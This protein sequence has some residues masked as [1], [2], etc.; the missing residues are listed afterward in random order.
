I[1]NSRHHEGFHP[2]VTRR[3]GLGHT[4]SSVAWDSDPVLWLIVIEMT[5][6]CVGAEADS[7][8]TKKHQ[9]KIIGEDEKEHVADKEV[10]EKPVTR[11]PKLALHVLKAVDHD[12]ET[13]PCDYVGQKHAQRIYEHSGVHAED[14]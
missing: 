1:A 9:Q 10:H 7:L 13:N 11:Q 8:P 5:D 6:Q 2:C 14:R 12:E 4:K 3:E